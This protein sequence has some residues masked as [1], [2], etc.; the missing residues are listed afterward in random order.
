[1]TKQNRQAD[2]RY[3]SE[4]EPSALSIRLARTND[5]TTIP[6]ITA[7]HGHVRSRFQRVRIVLVT[8]YRPARDRDAFDNDLAMAPPVARFLAAQRRGPRI[9]PALVSLSK[10]P[11]IGV[12]LRQA[13]EF[14][15]GSA[16]L[17]AAVRSPEPEPPGTRTTPKPDDRRSE[18]PPGPPPANHPAH[19]LPT[20]WL[21][22]LAPAIHR[23]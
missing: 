10:I 21:T 16:A 6:P 1:M 2:R 5:A 18:P 20:T 22:A 3:R 17:P 12:I 15:K 14:A 4:T 19:H 9:L 8:L 11:T 23:A 13:C 7:T